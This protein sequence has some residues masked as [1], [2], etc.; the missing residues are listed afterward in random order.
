MI[1]FA[2]TTWQ[3]AKA[4]HV[5][6]REENHGADLIDAMDLKLR[7][8]FSNLRLDEW[9]GRELRM[10]LYKPTDSQ[11]LEGVPETTPD[12]RTDLI[13]SPHSL[14][15]ELAGYILR[16]RRGMGKSKKLEVELPGADAKSFKLD[17]KP[18]GTCILT[19]TARVSGLDEE[20]MG[21]LSGMA[22]RDVE[23]MMIPPSLQT[24]TRPDSQQQ[25]PDATAAG[26][27]QQQPAA[28]AAPAP[29]VNPFKLSVV[30]G[31]LVDNNP[32]PGQGSAPM[33]PKAE[34][35][36]DATDAFVAAHGKKP[37]AKK[38]G[39]K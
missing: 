4:L 9:F 31:K 21:R 27:D 23:I 39:K 30:D 22:G 11:T 26:T 20:T 36:P 35:E 17:P 25:Q 7:F 3:G 24:G 29:G 38:T 10:A 18:G 37:A 13:E 14:K 19:F 32:T 34:K 15:T 2:L 8:E 12:K 28:G 5:N 33:D 16:V 6:K 1:Q